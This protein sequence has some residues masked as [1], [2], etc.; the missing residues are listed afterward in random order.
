M[1]TS[2][3]CADW[4]DVDPLAGGR[5]HVPG[6]DALLAD[7]RNRL[8]EQLLKE[9][10]RFVAYRWMAKQLQQGR[11]LSTRESS[12]A[13]KSPRRPPPNVSRGWGD[14]LLAKT[15]INAALASAGCAPVA[16]GMPSSHWRAA[17]VRALERP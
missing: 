16:E 11:K 5:G 4:L 3:N 2:T 17:G 8:Y 1:S 15:L 13:T 9:G 10:D 7:L 12:M 14:A 6:C